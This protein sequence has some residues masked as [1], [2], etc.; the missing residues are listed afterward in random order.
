MDEN[1]LP[2]PEPETTPYERL[3]ATLEDVVREHLEKNA[4]SQESKTDDEAV[5]VALSK[6]GTIDLRRRDARTDGD[7]DAFSDGI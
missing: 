1:R 5:S 7:E 2:E 3:L 4:P 6:R